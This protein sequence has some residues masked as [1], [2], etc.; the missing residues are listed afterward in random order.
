MGLRESVGDNR[1]DFTAE[2]GCCRNLNQ[3]IGRVRL[4]PHQ[5]RSCR[6]ERYDVAARGRAGHD[7]RVQAAK[8]E[9]AGGDGITIR[10]VTA[11]TCDVSDALRAVLEDQINSHDGPFLVGGGRGGGGEVRAWPRV[12]R[13]YRQGTSR[14]AHWMW[15]KESHC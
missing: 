4:V 6:V 1:Q 14:T 8:G 10:N 2:V 13:P 9:I 15:S 7:Q 11:W 5:L 12:P 3:P